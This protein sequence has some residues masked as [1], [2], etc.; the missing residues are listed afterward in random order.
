MWNPHKH[1]LL[2]GDEGR[3]ARARAP[4]QAHAGVILHEAD[5]GLELQHGVA[6]GFPVKNDVHGLALVREAHVGGLFKSR[7]MDLATTAESRW[8]QPGQ[9]VGVRKGILTSRWAVDR[10]V[11][12]A[13]S[14]FGKDSA[15][16]CQRRCKNSG[17][18]FSVITEAFKPRTSGNPSFSSGKFLAPHR[19]HF[20]QPSLLHRFGQQRE[21]LAFHES[22][23]FLHHHDLVQALANSTSK[24]FVQ[25]VGGAPLQKSGTHF[26]APSGG[27]P[28][29]NSSRRGRRHEAHFGRPRT[30]G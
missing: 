15:G 11:L 21:G 29:S 23:L 16:A 7:F 18:S 12:R 26:P 25:R 17:T 24:L 4:P 27:G 13:C 3:R 1:H 10:T 9:K 8:G 20:R 2:V 5:V 19:G 14:I 30:R 28:A 6:A 22:A